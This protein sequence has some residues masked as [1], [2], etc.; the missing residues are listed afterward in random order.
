MLLCL[1]AVSVALAIA[2]VF[3]RYVV[4]VLLHKFLLDKVLYLLNAD[5][6]AVTDVQFHQHRHAEN[7]ALRHDRAGILVRPA[8]SIYDLPAVVGYLSAVSFRYSLQRH[9]KRTHTASSPPNIM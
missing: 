3:F 7:I 1:A 2:N 9:K 8:D 5:I 6:L 4:E